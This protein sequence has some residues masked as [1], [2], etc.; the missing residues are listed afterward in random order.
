[1]NEPS[2]DPRASVTLEEAD[3]PDSEEGGYLLTMPAARFLLT[4]AQLGIILGFAKSMLPEVFVD[5][6]LSSENA[7]LRE[8][9]EALEAALRGVRVHHYEWQFGG[10]CWCLSNRTGATD[11]HD[12]HCLEARAA[13]AASPPE[14]TA[15]PL[16]LSWNGTEWVDDR[17]GCRFHP[18]DPNNN[19]GGGPHVHQCA[20]HRDRMQA[21]HQDVESS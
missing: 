20:F 13:L 21:G 14:G 19:H 11:E 2:Y 15:R 4:G 8:R 12:A 5:D 7:A 18:D 10:Y 3:R 16:H 17:C 6:R 1:M 9:V